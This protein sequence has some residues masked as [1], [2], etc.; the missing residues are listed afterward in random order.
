LSST[1]SHNTSDLEYLTAISIRVYT[2]D[3]VYT[4]SVPR[5]PGSMWHWKLVCFHWA[6]RQKFFCQYVLCETSRNHKQSSR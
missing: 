2:S 3:D 4:S 5:S 1:V 6:A